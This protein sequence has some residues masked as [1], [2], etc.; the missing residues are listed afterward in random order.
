MKSLGLAGRNRA[1]KHE[2][3]KMP[4]LAAL[5]DWPE[6]DW[7]VTKVMGRDVQK[8]LSSTTLAKLEKAMKMQP[9][10]IPNNNEW[11]DLLGF[12]KA[13][14]VQAVIE[15]APKKR[16]E[17]D[18]VKAN[19]LSNGAPRLKTGKASASASAS[20]SEAPR[21]K[22]AGK[23]RRYDEHSFEGY[24][25]GFVDDEG[26]DTVMT[27]VGGGPGYSSGDGSRKSGPSK[28]RRKVE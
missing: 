24:G 27:G 25:E 15:P 11:E 2:K 5:A 4:G 19:G 28:K 17:K 18:S 3:D 12:E 21:P 26:G 23:K 13:A 22:R 6:D 10:P 7:Q 16:K 1:V 8:G 20:A 9:G 14:P